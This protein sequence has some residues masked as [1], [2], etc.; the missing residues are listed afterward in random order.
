MIS[1]FLVCVIKKNDK[2]KFI[3]VLVN[4]PKWIVFTDFFFIALLP[5]DEQ[6]PC[7]FH[8]EPVNWGI[9]GQSSHVASFVQQV[10]HGLLW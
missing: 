8:D 7:C 10:Q 5:G 9:E 6:P 1:R 2:L 3:G 4:K